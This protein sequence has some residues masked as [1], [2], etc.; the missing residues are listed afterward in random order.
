MAKHPRR[1]YR[2]GDEPR[3]ALRAQDRIGRQRHFRAVEL[4]V[5][6]HAP[7]RLARPQRNECQVDAFG[8]DPSVDQRL[9]A[10]VTTAGKSQ[11]Y[12]LHEWPSRLPR[13]G[14]VIF[15]SPCGEGKGWG[16]RGNVKA[17]TNGS[18]L[19]TPH[20][21]LTHKGGGLL[22]DDAWIADALVAID[23]VDLLGLDLPADSVAHHA[24]PGPAGEHH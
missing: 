3:V 17:S 4:F 12:F 24:M 14:A 1:K 15:P 2:N 5:I 20:P 18:H 7:E 22:E 16:S 13:S 11:F 21:T 10:V 8:L 23:Q 9:R 6:E 19:P